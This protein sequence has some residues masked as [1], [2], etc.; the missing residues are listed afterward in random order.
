MI[1]IID[2]NIGNV[3]SIENMLKKIGVSCKTTQT[4]SDLNAAKGIILPGVGKFDYGIKQLTNLGFV[5]KL[6]EL[7]LE[8]KIPFLGICLGA[9]IMCKNSEEG[10]LNGL[11]WINAEVMKFSNLPS[12]HKIPHMGWNFV[13]PMVD[14]SLFY[15]FASN[16][17]FYFVHSY[18]ISCN[19]QDQI[20]GQTTYG[21][22]FPSVVGKENMFGVQFHPE[23][24]HKFGFQLLKNFSEIVQRNA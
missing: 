5:D 24:S 6:N 3:G 17:K 18:H 4:Q 7:V 23:K 10:D 9:Q 16:P 19:E 2:Y 22:Q 15:N 8:K 11:G 20:I 12:G 21:K 13:T 14:N 1:Y